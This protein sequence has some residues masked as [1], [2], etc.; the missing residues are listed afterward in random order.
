MKKLQILQI[1]IDNLKTTNH[2]LVPPLSCFTC[3][4]TNSLYGPHIVLFDTKQLR[5]MVKQM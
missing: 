5:L 1:A 4:R 3:I 2:G